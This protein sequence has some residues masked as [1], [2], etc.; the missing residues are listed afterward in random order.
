VLWAACDLE[1]ADVYA[2]LAARKG[3]SGLD[4]KAARKS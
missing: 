2:R 3:M 1:P 4:E